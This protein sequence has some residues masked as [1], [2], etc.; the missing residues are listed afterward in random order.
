M[1][2]VKKKMTIQSQYFAGTMTEMPAREDS[3]FVRVST[4]EKEAFREGADTDDLS[5]SDWLRK[6]AKKRVQELGIE[7][8]KPASQKRAAKKTSK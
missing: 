3:I 7:I 6:L 1:E 5:L 4:S 8:K 2:G